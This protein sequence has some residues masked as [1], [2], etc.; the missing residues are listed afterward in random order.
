M[1]LAKWV[2]I[3]SHYTCLKCASTQQ[4]SAW[5]KLHGFPTESSTFPE[6]IVKVTGG[7]HLEP[8]VV[9]VTR[10]TEFSFSMIFGTFCP[11]NLPK[12]SSQANSSGS[13]PKRHATSGKMKLKTSCEGSK[14]KEAKVEKQVE[15]NG[16]TKRLW[17]QK[18]FHNFFGKCIT[19]KECFNAVTSFNITMCHPVSASISTSIHV[20][21][22]II[23]LCNDCGQGHQRN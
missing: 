5:L 3:G 14:I 12:V 6:N 15:V 18:Q 16:E 7:Y 20:A 23:Q 9:A 1:S 8:A 4:A 22:N 2:T 17:N 19:F 21:S 11:W 13:G 10:L